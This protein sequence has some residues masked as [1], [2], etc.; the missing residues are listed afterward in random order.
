MNAMGDISNSKT[1]NNDKQNNRSTI[2]R[3][4]TTNIP[5]ISN[6]SRQHTSISRPASSDSNVGVTTTNPS[7]VAMIQPSI[8]RRGQ[9]NGRR[10]SNFHVATTSKL[11]STTIN[12]ITT[13]TNNGGAISNNMLINTSI[14]T[15]DQVPTSNVIQRTTDSDMREGIHDDSDK[16]NHMKDETKSNDINDHHNSNNDIANIPISGDDQVLTTILEEVGSVIEG[17]SIVND[18]SLIHI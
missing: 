10:N 2:I 5:I 14:T 12:N 3:T 15:I 17:E 11:S 13:N 8:Q 7:V 4:G 16:E 9:F 6:K 1:N 18:L